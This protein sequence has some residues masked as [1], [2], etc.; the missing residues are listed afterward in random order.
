MRQRVLG[1]ARVSRFGFGV[2]PKQSFRTAKFDVYDIAREEFAT[3]RTCSPACDTRAS[4]LKRFFRLAH[5]ARA[6][7]KARE[8]FQKSQR[9]FADRP[10]ALFRNNKFG[11]AGFFRARLF[12]FLVDLRPDK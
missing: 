11:F 10:I 1:S 2:A 12:V 3:G 5:I 8:L 7:F 9:D 6:S 4:T